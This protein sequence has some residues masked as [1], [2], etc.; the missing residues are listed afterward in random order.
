MVRWHCYAGDASLWPPPA[1]RPDPALR[2]TSQDGPKDSPN[3]R[4]HRPVT[5]GLVFGRGEVLEFSTSARQ[6]GTDTTAA[7]AKAPREVAGPAGCLAR[8]LQVWNHPCSMCQPQKRTP[9]FGCR[10]ISAGG[11]WDGL[12]PVTVDTRH[13][14]AQRADL[15]I[16][17]ADVNGR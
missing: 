16:A 7:G 5:S 8:L 14:S 10:Q 12:R 4:C 13:G 11:S 6:G 17:R 1:G 9:G 2:H 15:R 3:G